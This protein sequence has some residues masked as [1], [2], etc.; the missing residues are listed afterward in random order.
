MSSI[1]K[2]ILILLAIPVALLIGAGA[3]G[4]LYGGEAIL[5]GII[6]LVVGVIGAVLINSEYKKIS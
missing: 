1:K 4:I 2:I 5:R 3:I 6:F